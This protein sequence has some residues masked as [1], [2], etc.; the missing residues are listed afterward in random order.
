MLKAILFDLDDTLIDWGGFSDS[1][2]GWEEIERRHL[3]G[4]YDYICDRSTPSGSLESYKEAYMQR[5]RDA[6]T[7]ARNTLLAPHLGR[8]LIEAAADVGIPAENLHVEEC[9]KAYNWRRVPGTSAFPDVF[10]G[11]AMLREKGLKFGIVTNAFQPMWLRDVEM[12]EHGLLEFFPDCRFSAADV[13]YLKPHPDIFSAALTCLDTTPE[14]TIFIG[15]NPIADIAG[16]QAAGMLAV[17]RVNRSAKPLLSGL[18]VPDGAINSLTELPT[19][20]DEWYPGW[21]DGAG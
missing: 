7:S 10:E 19:Y 11:L 17:L 21:N 3:E 5:A 9:L 12:A 1:S 18:V 4:V 2:V 6:W 15:D 20:L 14:E 16:A 13:G 8:I